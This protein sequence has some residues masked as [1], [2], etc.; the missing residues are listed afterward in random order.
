MR[1][2]EPNNTQRHPVCRTSGVQNGAARLQAIALAVAVLAS[3]T[4]ER[5]KGPTTVLCHCR[6]TDSTSGDGDM[7]TLWRSRLALG[8]RAWRA[9][10][11][12]SLVMVGETS[13]RIGPSGMDVAKALA[14]IEADGID[15]SSLWVDYFDE[16]DLAE[17]THEQLTSNQTVSRCRSGPCE[18]E[19]RERDLLR[20]SAREREGGRRA[21]EVIDGL[22][23]RPL[24]QSTAQAR[25]RSPRRDR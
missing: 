3:A 17:P 21:L 13:A 14:A 18:T 16:V 1:R 22:T 10:D 24:S 20:H 25:A 7:T 6:V 23:F 4:T 19:Q 11:D 2:A 8:F 15:M 12:P 5:G 9:P